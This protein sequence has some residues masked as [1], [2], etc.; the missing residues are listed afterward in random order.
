MC[1]RIPPLTEQFGNIAKAELIA[2]SPE[3]VQ[4]DNV[5][6]ELEIVKGRARALV[7]AAVAGTTGEPGVT[8][9]GTMLALGSCFRAAMRAGHR[10]LGGSLSTLRQAYSIRALRSDRTRTLS[11]QLFSRLCRSCRQLRLSHLERC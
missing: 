6:G 11:C 3:D 2:K 8:K 7:V 5:S 1:D 4:E 10:R 9:G